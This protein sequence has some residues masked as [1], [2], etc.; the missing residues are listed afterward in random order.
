MPFA[1][2]FRAVSPIVLLVT[3]IQLATSN[4]IAI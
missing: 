4:P 2:S 3:L 1:R